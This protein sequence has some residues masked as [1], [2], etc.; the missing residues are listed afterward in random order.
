MGMNRYERE[1]VR[2]AQVAEDE[3]VIRDTIFEGCDVRGPAI[4]VPLEGTVIENNR[5]NADDFDAVLWEVAP[6][7]SR[8]IG[9]IGLEN[10]R[11]TGCQFTQVGIAGPADVIAQFRGQAD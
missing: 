3:G 2:I 4:L 6:D 10:C 1:V 7:R 5:F 8:V 11:F 9:A